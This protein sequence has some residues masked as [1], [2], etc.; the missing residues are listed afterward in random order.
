[1]DVDNSSRIAMLFQ[2]PDKEVECVPVFSED[3]DLFVR[4]IRVFQYLNEFCELGSV[5]RLIY[6]LSELYERCDD[7]SLCFQVFQRLGQNLL[8]QKTHIVF[9]RL[10]SVFCLLLLGCLI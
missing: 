10:E 3:E 4:V 1:M 7:L 2:L 9:A 8:F 5:S 6:T